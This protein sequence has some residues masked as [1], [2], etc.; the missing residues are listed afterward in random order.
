M[1]LVAY[2]D[3]RVGAV[4]GSR[5]VDLTDLVSSPG[6]AWPP[7]QM[8]RLIKDFDRLLPQVEQLLAAGQ[9]VELDTVRLN[10]P[11]QWP[12]KLV[13]FPA[14]YQRHID[15]MHSV[16]RADHN[17]F[18][19]KSN[20]SIVGPRDAIVL[21]PIAGADVHHECE[22]ALVIG[23]EG[24]NVP[25]EKALDYIFGFMCLLDITVRGKQERVAR[26]SFDTFTPIGPWI[27]TSDEVPD[28]RAIDLRLTVNGELR[29][30]ANTRDLILGI[31]EMIAMTS[32]ISTIYPGDI[33]ATGTPEGVGPI[34]AGDEVTIT[35]E[36]VGTMTLPVLASPPVDGYELQQWATREAV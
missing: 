15:E 32:A 13:A 22:L 36:S 17:G 21:P 31:P 33:I 8:L 26:K 2:G 24:R 9:S 30:S 14:N 18:F 28:C 11:I 1:K 34:H 20:A 4:H 27:V 25:V 35:I 10:A 5:V 6:A 29:Q 23:R 3:D 7:A 12:N 16:N 19:L